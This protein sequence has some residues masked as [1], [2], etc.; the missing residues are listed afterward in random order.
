MEI[1]PRFWRASLFMALGS[2]YFLLAGCTTGPTRPLITWATPAA[3]AYGTPLSA[4]QLDATVATDGTFSYDPPLGTVLHAGSQTLSVTFTPTDTSEY[5]SATSSVT[6]TV[7]QATSMLSWAT[8]NAVISGTPLSATQLDATASVPGV[9]VYNPAAGI[10]LPVGSQTLSVSFTPNDATDYATAT[11]TVTLS[12]VNA[13]AE[14]SWATPAAIGFGTPLGSAQLDATSTIAGSFTYSP[15]AGTVLS[16]GSYTL[17]VNFT[18]TD[19]SKYTPASAQV[20]LTVTKGTPRIVWVPQDPIV[21]GVGLT[22]AQLNATADPPGSN[23]PVDGSFVYSPGIGTVFNSLGKQTL[24]VTFTPDNTTDFTA[25]EGSISDDVVSPFS[26]VA[27]GDSL[28]FGDQGIDEG[29]YPDE[30]KPL[31]VLPVVNEGVDGNTSTQIGVREGGIPTHA[32]VHGGSIPASGAV[33][34]TFPAGYEPVTVKGPAGGT[35]GTIVGVHGVVTLDSNSGV[36]SFTR[37]TAGAAVSAGGSPQFIVDTPYANDLPVF[38]EGRDNYVSTDQ[39]KSDLAAQVA[40]V[41]SG[42]DFLVMSIINVNSQNEWK[43]GPSYNIIVGFNDQLAAIYG[44][45]YLDIR[46]VLVDSYNPALVTDV[47]DHEHDEVPT[48]LRAVGFENGTLANSISAGD[49][50]ITVNN[51]VAAQYD[52]GGSILTIG[53]GANAEN[54]LVTGIIGSTSNGTK[55]A[56]QRNFGGNDTSHA[57]GSPV[58]GTD[59]THL[60]AQGER[61]VAGAVAGYLSA[62]ASH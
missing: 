12:V 2:S 37:S 39:I 42:Q 41:R 60:N 28:T 36:Y 9:F 59:Y 34:V 54:V 8:P 56:V 55:L 22:S 31:I 4:K 20:S 1:F 58:V 17:S 7:N 44:A 33:T 10:V 24:S 62:Y 11:A 16:I 45:H 49:T 21:I 46:K 15:P 35:P 5:T 61:V 13:N 38:W 27:W 30:L 43:G 6:L 51:T 26:V 53:A 3:I 32:T 48:S 25:T 19:I 23:N 29:N 18:P 47:S 40:T 52:A 50:T 14:I 57:A